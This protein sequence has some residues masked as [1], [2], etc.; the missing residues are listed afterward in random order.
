MTYIDD[1]KEEYTLMPRISKERE[2]VRGAHGFV[3]IVGH[4]SKI[5]LE[6]DTHAPI[7]RHKTF[8]E[9]V[10]AVGNVWLAIEA[11][12]EKLDLKVAVF[13]G[14]GWALSWELYFS[15]RDE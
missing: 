15:F 5:G 9:L 10:P 4:I 3:D 14:V 11:V 7:G 12:G 2:P 8:T 6:S 1:H 13:C